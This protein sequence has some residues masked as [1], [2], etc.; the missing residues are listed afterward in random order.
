MRVLLDENVPRKLKHRFSP[1]HFVTTVQ[2]RGWAGVENGAL[3][4]AAADEFDALVTLD[5]GIEYQQDMSG[6]DLR[7]IVVSASS[8]RYED[9]LPVVPAIESAL[10]RLGAGEVALVAG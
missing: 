6:L 1:P 10:V 2:E 7:L 9:L 8:N 5:R 4:Q 3:L